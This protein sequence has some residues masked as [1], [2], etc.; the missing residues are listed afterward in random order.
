VKHERWRAD[1]RHERRPAGPAARRADPDVAG[2]LLAVQSGAGNA[3]TAQ[4]LARSSPPGRGAL[5]VQRNEKFDAAATKPFN[6]A[7]APENMKIPA[8]LKDGLQAA[9]DASFPE[10]KSQEQG[11]IL[12]LTK[13]GKYVWRAGVG[14]GSGSF[15]VNYGDV[16]E[17]EVLIASAHTHPY[18]ESEGGDT[19]VSFSGGDLSNLVWQKERVK[20]VQSGEAQ[21][22][23]AKTAE[24][25]A[26]VAKA[27][28]KEK[29][30][31][32]RKEMD[33][34]WNDTFKGSKGTFQE[35]VV[36]AATAV[37]SKYHLVYMEGKGGNLVTTGKPK[38]KAKAHVEALAPELPE[39]TE[40]KQAASEVASTKDTTAAAPEETGILAW[41][42][43]KLRQIMGN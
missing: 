15:K 38:P 1:E 2:R 32:L 22:G 13:E 28:T 17:G 11:G 24:F 26:L 42:K 5:A 4:L 21:F 43:R 33:A 16:K 34:L 39:S 3:A 31:A 30:L 12:V 41:F 7:D 37:C 40:V 19:D 6:E 36:A 10:G 18:D 8:E 20:V 14:T 35:G 25:D 9:W 27:D 29:Q 23:V